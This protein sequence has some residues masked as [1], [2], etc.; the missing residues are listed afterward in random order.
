VIRKPLLRLLLTAILAAG[1]GLPAGEAAAETLKHAQFGIAAATY[2]DV[3]GDQD[4]FPD[5]GETGRLVLTVRNGRFAYTGAALVLTSS[6]PEVV[7]VPGWEVPIGSLAP[8]QVVDVGSLAQTVPR[9][10][11]RV[12]A[13]IASA[14]GAE[15]ARID[16]CVRLRTDQAPGLSPPL[17]FF[18]PADLDLPGGTTQTFIAGPDG[19]PGTADDGSLLE[20]FDADRNGDGL[21][22]VDDTFRGTDAGTGLLVHG[23]YLRP[24]ALPAQGL[25]S[26]LGCG[27]FLAP[28][29]DP[30]D[31]YSCG[32]DRDLPMDWHL[33]CPPGATSCPN[34]QSGP[35]ADG[36]SGAAC[37]YATPADGQK[38]SSPPNSLHMGVHFAGLDSL[39]D[40][41]RSKTV[42]AFVSAPVNLAPIPRPG[43]LQLAMFQIADL[44]D[45]E[46]V[47]PRAAGICLDCADV[48]VQ[49]D[50][51]PSPAVDAWGA[52]DKL[53]PFQ[54]IY[55]HVPAASSIYG[56][57]YCI[58]TP[59]DTGPAP[60]APRGFHETM[61][62][63]QGAWSRCGSVRGTA[64]D[65]V[66][67]CEG[68]GLVDPSGVGVWSETRFDLAPLRGQRIRIRWIGSTWLYDWSAPHYP[69]MGGSWVS[70]PD[71][72][73]WWI[74][75][76]RITGVV[77]TQTTPVPDS[78]PA[79]TGGL[80]PEV[81]TDIDGDGYGSPG[82]SLCGGGP[83]ADCNDLQ[84]DIHPG[85]PEGCNKIDNDCDGLL[86]IDERDADQDGHSICTG[87]CDDGHSHTYPHARE[88]NDG[89]DNQC[90]GDV[91]Y[92]LVDELTTNILFGSQGTLQSITQDGS[93]GRQIV[94]SPRV[95]FSSDCT[96][97]TITTTS[98]LP[99]PDA[100]PPGV[101]W[102]YLARAS[103]P[104]VGSWGASSAGVE[105]VVPCVP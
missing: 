81:C 60:P 43:D 10:E 63:A 101:A 24:A 14:S 26:A 87:D 2:R 41:V 25:F 56:P 5:P 92:G 85:A 9:F 7:C 29:S 37:T 94:R 38:A 33:H 105:R 35:C 96:L 30:W 52:W 99:Q 93:T 69:A 95:D 90:P 79:V 100:P 78:H 68:P 19:L 71:E 80:C 74:D 98:F 84:R 22:T 46:H 36:L 16:L 82:S 64:P 42:Q 45:I 54:N 91:G 103:A 59:T 6:D 27:G 47:D 104:H 57:E 15:P 44:M 76:V 55:D 4:A 40:S 17:C 49:V 50:R 62:F 48:Q 39:M 1:L 88:Y 58:L 83:T 12:A 11:F 31:D 21:F 77:T 70:N 86:S 61:C 20:N 89:R 13:T 8:G 102:F 32:V 75:D 28:P 53:A 23:E 3:D 97:F 73:G 72:D 65:S 34:I 66:S 51:D 18:L 67:N